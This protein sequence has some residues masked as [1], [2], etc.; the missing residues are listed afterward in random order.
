L[1]WREYQ[2]LLEGCK[3]RSSRDWEHTRALLYQEAAINRDPKK[4]LLPMR[5]WMP[6]ITDQEE[7]I[8]AVGSHLK[9]VLADYK[10]KKK[11]K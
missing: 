8:K 11:K 2:L 5:Q 10:A 7:D 9:Q 6:L 1:T 4:K 3:I